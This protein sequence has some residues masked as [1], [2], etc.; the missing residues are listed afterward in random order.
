MF[1]PHS[2]SQMEWEHFFLRVYKLFHLICGQL[3][4][5]YWECSQIG[6]SDFIENTLAILISRFLIIWLGLVQSRRQILLSRSSIR[7]WVD[8]STLPQ[9]MYW[10]HSIAKS[11]MGG[12]IGNGRNLRDSGCVCV[13]KQT[14]SDSCRLKVC[15]LPVMYPIVILSVLISILW[16]KLHQPNLRSDLE[17]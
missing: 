7:G 5:L 11:K 3:T 10:V 14:E 12:K 9:R 4:T 15:S 6:I 16:Y 13:H 17:S 8:L 1:H 2:G